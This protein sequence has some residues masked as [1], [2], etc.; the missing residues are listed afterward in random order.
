MARGGAGL[1]LCRHVA[2]HGKSGLGLARQHHRQAQI[3][4]QRD[5][6]R[7]VD[8]ALLVIG[9]GLLVLALLIHDHAQGVV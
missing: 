9:L 6:A 1:G 2:Q 3:V 5:I 7:A 4:A 8:Q